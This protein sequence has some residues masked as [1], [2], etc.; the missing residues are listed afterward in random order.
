MLNLNSFTCNKVKI[1]YNHLLNSVIYR[2]TGRE[3]RLRWPGEY[4]ELSGEP[5]ADKEDADQ[6]RRCSKP[7]QAAGA[8][9]RVGRTDLRGVLCTGMGRLKEKY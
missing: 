3:Q 6:V 2:Y 9:H 4:Q 8:L 5:S 7:L 1:L